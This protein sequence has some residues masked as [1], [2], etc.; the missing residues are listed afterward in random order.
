MRRTIY[1]GEATQN[2]APNRRSMRYSRCATSP[3]GRMAVNPQSEALTLVGHTPVSRF[4]GAPSSRNSGHQ[5]SFRESAN[6]T[7]EPGM[8]LLDH[9]CTAHRAKSVSENELDGSG[10]ELA[11]SPVT[12]TPSR[13]MYHSSSYDTPVSD[14]LSGDM[15]VLLQQQ[16][17]LLMEILRKQSAIED[18]QTQFEA[19]LTELD[20]KISV[21][22]A[23][24]TSG[25]CGGK[26][27]RTVNRSLSVR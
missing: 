11:L 19:K 10:S 6:S 14:Q 21:P 16:Q 12:S 7:Y 4:H 24:D 8:R 2:E 17:G 13:R 1:P 3:R 9:P 27:K 26:R 5:S 25:S 20:R 22:V 15:R 23:S 18:R